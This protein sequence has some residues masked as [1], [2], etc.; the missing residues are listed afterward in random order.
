MANT[1]DR[2][3]YYRDDGVRIVHDPYAPGMVEKYGRPGDTDNEGFDPYADTV[4]PGIYGGV[5]KRDEVG[6]VVVGRQYQDHNP[7]PGPVYAGGGY[8]PM[9]I[10]LRRGEAALASLLDKYPDLVNEVSTGGATPL[11][12]CGMGRSSEA[13][14]AFIVSR[15][16]DIEAED[17]YGYRPLHRMASN[18]LAVGARA[19]LS[20]GAD[21]NACTA[22]GETALSIA[23]ESRATDVIAVLRE[24]TSSGAAD[25][26]AKTCTTNRA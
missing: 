18:N 11:H 12:M 1:A 8:T 17:T 10:A 6:R 14:T 23:R 22:Q 2:K 21:P 7:R 4:G 16:G 13:A 25:A 3:E 26:S 9:T 20:A 19:L 24:Y 15:G 5:V